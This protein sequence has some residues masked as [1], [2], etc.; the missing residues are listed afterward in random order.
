MQ[1]QVSTAEAKVS[2]RAVRYETLESARRSRHRHRSLRRRTA[3]NQPGQCRLRCRLNC[4]RHRRPSDDV[5]SA[6]AVA[7][8][9]PLRLAVPNRHVVSPSSRDR[10]HPVRSFRRRRRRPLRNGA[11]A[12]QCAC[13]VRTSTQTGALLA[14]WVTANA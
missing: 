8:L 14:Q 3:V 1:S 11:D 6:S 9:P 2:L 7:D 4:R 12:W 10:R 13:A 5:T